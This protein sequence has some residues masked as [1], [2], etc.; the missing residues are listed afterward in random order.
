MHISAQRSSRDIRTTGE[1]TIEEAPSPASTSEVSKQSEAQKMEV[2]PTG[3][4]ASR[5]VMGQPRMSKPTREETLTENAHSFFAAYTSGDP[6]AMRAQLAPGTVYQDPVFPHLEG[7]DQ[8]G[9]MWKMVAGGGTVHA[10]VQNVVAD[11]KGAEVTWVA[12]YKFLGADIE[13]HIQTRLSFD[14]DGRI[15]QQ[16]DTF[17]WRAWGNQ[18]PFPV[19]YLLRTSVGQRLVQWALGRRLK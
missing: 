7:Q 6:A 13:N 12:K 14:D 18:T 3:M 16:V 5:P 4:D 1:E 15:T 10:D 17:D 9:R 19:R 8:V 11:K 2:Y